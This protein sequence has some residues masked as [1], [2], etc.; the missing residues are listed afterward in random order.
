[1]HMSKAHTSSAPLG[2]ERSYG[3]FNFKFAYILLAAAA[4]GSAWFLI[5]FL[6]CSFFGGVASLTVPVAVGL[7]SGGASFIALLALSSSQR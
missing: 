5:S 4:N 6:V 7:L 2:Q 3:A 1:M